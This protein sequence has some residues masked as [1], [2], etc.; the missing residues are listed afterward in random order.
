MLA[1]LECALLRCP[2]P[3]RLCSCTCNGV[4]PPL[5]FPGFLRKKLEF[6]DVR[7]RFCRRAVR[8]DGGTA[9]LATPLSDDRFSADPVRDWE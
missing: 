5:P 2:S 1:V 7:L 4:L 3:G 9:V 6:L 8:A